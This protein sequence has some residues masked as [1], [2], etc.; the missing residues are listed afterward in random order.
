MFQ[1]FQF[2]P[3]MFPVQHRILYD[4]TLQKHQN[5]FEIAEKDDTLKGS[6]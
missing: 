6:A 1:F 3:V 5:W 4:Q 2:T